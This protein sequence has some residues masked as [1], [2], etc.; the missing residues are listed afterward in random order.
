MRTGT[1]LAVLA[2][3]SFGVTTPLVARAGRGLDAFT[4]AALLYAGA[5]GS[6]L[7]L[8]RF[9]PASGAPLRRTDLSRLLAIA[10]CGAGIAPVLFAWGLQRAGAT[11]SSLLL[12]LEV[13]FTLLLA[14]AFYREPFGRR[15]AFALGLMLSGGVVLALGSSAEAG[16]S[17]L[18][19][20]AI[21]GATLAWALDNTLSRA[22]AE[23]D[24]VFV[25]AGKGAL[26]ALLTAAVALAVGAPRPEMGAVLALCLCGATG[27]GLSLRLYLMAQRH[28]GAA[29]TASIFA[30]A[31]FI[32]AALGWVLD[33]TWPSS[34]S[35]LAAGCFGLGVF[36]HATERHRHLHSHL[37]HEHEHPHRH[38]DGHHEH[39]HDPPF[40]GEHS[41][42]HRHEAIEHE[43][44][45]SPD[46]HHE[47][48]EER[49]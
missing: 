32:G 22:L 34:W 41:H 43:H 49:G 45:H 15:V 8:G 46:A 23:Y 44:D 48:E 27:Y 3:L 18:G 19:A 17:A 10:V 6:A 11:T 47:R 25:V 29:R 39:A 7:L 21:A 33:H 30:L 4:T 31:P 14:R 12:N 16:W 38:D 2:A 1:S 28:I 36:L 37:R 42:P 13:V 24:P 40:R 9:A 26:G 20:L 35:L 5:C